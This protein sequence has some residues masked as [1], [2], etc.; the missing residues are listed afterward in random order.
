[1]LTKNRNILSDLVLEWAKLI[2]SSYHRTLYDNLHGMGAIL[3]P[4][5]DWLNNEAQDC[6]LCVGVVGSVCA[7]L[8]VLHVSSDRNLIAVNGPKAK[9]QLNKEN[10]RVWLSAALL[11][12][13]SSLI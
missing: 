12:S 8:H 9:A 11:G 5:S 6:N 10:P 4:L 2:L 13:S 3:I 7:G 1:M